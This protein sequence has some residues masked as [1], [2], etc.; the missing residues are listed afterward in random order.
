[1]LS[2]EPELTGSLIGL[3]THFTGTVVIDGSN[4]KWYG[5]EVSGF[6][7]QFHLTREEGAWLDIR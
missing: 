1:V 3:V 2:G 6:R 4:R 7:K 5:S